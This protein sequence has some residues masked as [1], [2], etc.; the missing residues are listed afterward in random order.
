MRYTALLNVL[1]KNMEN[2]VLALESNDSANFAKSLY[3]VLGIGL[4]V[5]SGNSLKLT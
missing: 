3:N 5:V 4:F 1:M 2:A